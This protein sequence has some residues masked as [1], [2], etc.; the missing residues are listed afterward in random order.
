MSAP[1]EEDRFVANVIDLSDLVHELVSQC[2][3]SGIRDIN[4]ILLIA[5][6]AY[7]QSY[8][9]VE[10]IRTFIQ[11]SHMYWDE[12]HD[13]SEEFFITHSHSVFA[14]I[15]VGKGNIDAFKMLFTSKDPDGEFIIG[16][17]DRDAIWDMFDSLVKICIK[18]IH[19]ER[20]CQLEE[21]DGRMV[22]RYKNNFMPHIKVRGHA[23]K[24]GVDL[25][26]PQV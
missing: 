7:L 8:N 22:P 15:P 10:F 6:K 17:E 5:A 12:I 26:I 3:D 21:R 20:N 18:Y 14:H 16:P 11:Y 19:R 24:W 4:P 25:E 9:R 13:R 2:W 23:H 1:P